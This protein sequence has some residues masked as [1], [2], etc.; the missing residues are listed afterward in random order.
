MDKLHLNQHIVKA[1]NEKLSDIK[2]QLLTMGALV[3]EQ[4]QDSVSAYFNDDLAL[5]DNIM[6]KERRIDDLE[7]FIDESC[8]ELIALR[9]PA[10]SDL[11]MILTVSK[12]TCDLERIGDE[13]YKISK[14][15]IMTSSSD[16]LGDKCND[17]RCLG[18]AV[19][20][21]LHD[22]LVAFSDFD[23]NAAMS[24]I[25]GDKEIDKQFE[26][27]LNS[28]IASF[29]DDSHGAVDIVPILGVLRALERIAGHAKNICEQIVFLV[30]GRDIRHISRRSEP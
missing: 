30:Q 1:Y 22:A 21:L 2:S 13:A 24:I 27:A 6:D 4:V 12:V 19:L 16:S 28:M 3:E 10:A 9:Q 14:L 5:T 20:K 17:L 11:R 15:T 29:K 26:V 18:K 7:V 23:D 8:T 25:G